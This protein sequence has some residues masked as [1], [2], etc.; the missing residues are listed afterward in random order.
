MYNTN[1][2]ERDGNGE[3]EDKKDQNDDK[4]QERMYQIEFDEAEKEFGTPEEG[5]FDST[6][7]MWTLF[8]E[9]TDENDHIMEDVGQC[10]VQDGVKA[11]WHSQH[12]W[13][14]TALGGSQLPL[15]IFRP[16]P[17]KDGL[18]EVKVQPFWILHTVFRELG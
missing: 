7:S 10:M 11:S 18:A 17:R 4:D 5:E 14:A 8:E 6:E 9:D 13:G 15:A 2:H 1:E 16:G 3:E 12:A